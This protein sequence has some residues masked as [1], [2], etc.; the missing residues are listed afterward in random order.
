MDIT[1]KLLLI[2]PIIDNI[3]HNIVAV[4][5]YS[6]KSAFG[7]ICNTLLSI[8]FF[9]WKTTIFVQNNLLLYLYF[10]S[11][12]GVTSRILAISLFLSPA[13]LKI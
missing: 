13:F 5:V 10:V 7:L 1:E 12:A 2:F 4:L 3:L 6:S 11:A 8:K 9:F